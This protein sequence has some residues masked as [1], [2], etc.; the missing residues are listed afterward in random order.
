MKVRTQTTT[1]VHIE[2]HPGHSTRG[3]EKEGLGLVCHGA[4]VEQVR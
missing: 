3:K 4:F 1:I 2:A